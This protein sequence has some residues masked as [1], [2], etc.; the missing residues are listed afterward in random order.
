MNEFFDFLDDAACINL[1]LSVGY[2]VPSTSNKRATPRKRKKR[3][4]L[5]KIYKLLHCTIM[6]WVAVVL[7][8]FTKDGAEYEQS[9][10]HARSKFVTTCANF[11]DETNNFA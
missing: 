8:T 4:R 1:E 9:K 3:S 6:L 7:K 2:F 10:N 5:L 11:W